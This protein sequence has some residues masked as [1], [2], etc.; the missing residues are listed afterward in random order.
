[1]RDAFVK[2][3]IEEA[4]KDRNIILITGDLGFGVLDEFQKELPNQFINSGV[5]EQSMMGMAAGI[6][7]T[8]KRVFVYSIGNFPTLRC[9]EQIRNDVCLMNNSVV[10]V[11]VGAGYAYGPQGYTHH[12]LEDIAVMRALPNL[13]VVIPA[14]PI[15]ASL[16]TR[17]LAKS[18]SP[19]YLRL[20]KSNEKVIHLYEPK[21][22]YGR[23]NEVVKGNKGTILFVGSAGTVAL[24]AAAKL[25]GD[26]ID[27]AVV[28]VP[29]VSSL[30]S[31]YLEQAAQKGPIITVEEHS[32]RGGFAGA[33]LEFLNEKNIQVQVGTISAQQKN[34][35][36]IG[37]QE[38][39]RES[40]GI[41]VDA[42]ISKFKALQED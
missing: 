31:D 2:S 26:G 3:L 40:N 20:G 33:I 5:N 22:E 12:A 15:E 27:V 19:T 32:K 24:E 37:S 21:I 34:L 29:F 35:S 13:D 6:A 18:K 10:V 39:L 23:F 25:L 11:S 17:L 1:M 28:S 14:D 38:F 16:I 7:S 8:G 4:K 42:V 36:Q 30:D 41:S 9:L